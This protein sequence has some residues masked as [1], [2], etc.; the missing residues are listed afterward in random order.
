M[1]DPMANNLT[2]P[3]DAII[4]GEIQ[5]LGVLLEQHEQKWEVKKFMGSLVNMEENPSKDYTLAKE[6][7][8]TNIRYIKTKRRFWSQYRDNSMDKNA[9]DKLQEDMTDWI[10]NV[11]AYLGMSQHEEQNKRIKEEFKLFKLIFENA[12]KKE[13]RKRNK[14]LIS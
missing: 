11:W 7:H 1:A 3:A 9:L 14:K 12:P 13:K 10:T 5:R 6:Y 4:N 2:R 8:E